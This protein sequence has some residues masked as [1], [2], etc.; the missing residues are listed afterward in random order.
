M[1]RALSPGGLSRAVLQ[2]VL[3]PAMAIATGAAAAM[4]YEGW[5]EHDERGQFPPPGVVVDVG[6]GQSMHVRSWGNIATGPTIVLTPGAAIPSSAFAWIGQDLAD[7]YR[8]VAVDRPG[9]GWSSGG[10]GPRDALTAAEDIHAA[11]AKAGFPPPYVIA[12][13]S[14]GGFAARVFAGQYVTDVAGVIFLDASHPDAPGSGYGFIYRMQALRGHLGEGYLFPPG[15]GYAD[16]P[17]ADA[18]RTYAVDRW[19]SHLDASADELDRWDISAT[20]ARSVTSLGATPLLVISTPIQPEWE[21]DLANLS[22][23]S[24]FVILNV[25]HTQMLSE[26]DQAETVA[27]EI[28]SFLSGQLR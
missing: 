2:L 1:N 9:M 24:H 22:S 7:Q 13:H 11:L 4:L 8:V 3:A 15:N 12:G 28:E 20:E 25:G 6:G 21:R 23:A 27:T 10:S 19:T 16:L 17:P 26:P 5:M 18:A 14:F